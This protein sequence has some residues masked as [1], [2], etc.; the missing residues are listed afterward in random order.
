MRDPVFN[1]GLFQNLV[2]DGYIQWGTAWESCPGVFL[3]WD[4]ILLLLIIGPHDNDAHM[5][6][7]WV[8][9]GK[10]AGGRT[11]CWEPH[12]GDLSQP[13]TNSPRDSGAGLVGAHDHLSDLPEVLQRQ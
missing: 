11:G 3:F 8:D 7:G 5:E 9:T 2:A 1:I 12:L 13:G 4:I 6:E 10:P